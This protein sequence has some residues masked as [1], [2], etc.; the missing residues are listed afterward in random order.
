MKNSLKYTRV[1]EAQCLFE[2]IKLSSKWYIRGP[3]NL[4]WR[5]AE[6]QR[7]PRFTPAYTISMIKS[8]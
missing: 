4:G 3:K 7:T 1:K 2:Q 8:F 6:T 5:R